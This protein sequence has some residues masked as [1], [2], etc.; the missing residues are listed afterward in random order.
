MDRNVVFVIVDFVD[1]VVEVLEV[2][3]E[4]RRNSPPG[5]HLQHIART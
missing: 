1:G 4:I 5:E 3:D 2:I